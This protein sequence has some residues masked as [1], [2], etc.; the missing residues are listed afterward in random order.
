MELLVSRAGVETRCFETETRLWGTETET[1]HETYISSFSLS[2]VYGVRVGNQSSIL[3]V[4][5]ETKFF[6]FNI[7]NYAAARFFKCAGVGIG[8]IFF[9]SIP[10]PIFV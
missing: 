4:A 8:F 2:Q 5:V 1:R 9:F 10:I 7:F 6:F 3:L